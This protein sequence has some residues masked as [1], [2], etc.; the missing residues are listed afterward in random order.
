VNLRN[1]YSLGFEA[2]SIILEDLRE[3]V[4][5]VGA[6]SPGAAEISM[7]L[8]SRI[9]VMR[10]MAFCF[11]EARVSDA[12]WFVCLKAAAKVHLKLMIG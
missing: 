3:I 10:P 2:P 4:A 8:R 9:L 1:L 11:F 7:G 6:S 12:I 5:R